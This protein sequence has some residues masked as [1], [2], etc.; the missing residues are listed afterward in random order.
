MWFSVFPRNISARHES[1][2]TRTHDPPVPHAPGIYGQRYPRV[3]ST[4]TPTAIWRPG[5]SEPEGQQ[6]SHADGDLEAGAKRARGSTVLTR[7]K[8][9]GGRG[10]ASPRVNSTHTPTTI[11]RP[12]PS[13]PE[14][15]QYSHADGDLEAGAKRAQESTVLTRRRRSGGRGQASPR[16]NSTHTPTAIWRPGPSEPESTVLTRRRR[17][18]GRGQASPRVNSTHTPTAIWRPGPSESGTREV[19]RL[20]CSFI[21]TLNRAERRPSNTFKHILNRAERRPSKTSGTEQNGDLQT[22]SKTS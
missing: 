18:G 5:P 20:R 19:T 6:Y 14:S 3:N 8:R 13:E 11:W 16:V 15:Q 2:G 9:S 4:H 17:S 7:R 12:G 1:A 10:Q 21:R 22:P